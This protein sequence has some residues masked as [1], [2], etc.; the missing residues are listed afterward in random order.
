MHFVAHSFSPRCV[1]NHAFLLFY[2][3]S[4]WIAGDLAAAQLPGLLETE[5]FFA[6]V[7]VAQ[8][9]ER[10]GEQAQEF[11]AFFG[12]FRAMQMVQ[13]L[14]QF[15]EQDGSEMAAGI[16]SFTRVASMVQ[17]VGGF[18][19]FPPLLTAFAVKL[20]IGIT[21]TP[22]IRNVLMGNGTSAKVFGEN[23][24]HFRQI[25]QPI[26]HIAAEEAIFN[27]VVELIA[28]GFRQTSDFA[29]SCFHN[30]FFNR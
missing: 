27:F 2:A 19:D 11:P 13:R 24:F 9:R 1:P 15:D 5:P 25:I 23:L 7:I 6:S 18:D 8:A 26:G 17:G 29:G 14:T 12:I 30:D 21:G 20:P 22:P 16:L 10:A 3:R 28:D 4:G